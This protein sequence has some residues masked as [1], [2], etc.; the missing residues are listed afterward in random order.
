MEVMIMYSKEQAI[1]TGIVLMRSVKMSPSEQKL[2]SNI[3]HQDKPTQCLEADNINRQ[4]LEVGTLVE[5]TFENVDIL[6][7]CYQEIV[8]KSGEGD[9]MLDDLVHLSNESNMCTDL[10]QTQI[11]KTYSSANYIKETVVSIS[12]LAYKV[13]ILAMNANIE[14]A[15]AGENGR[16]F[17]TIAKEVK[18]LA[19]QTKDFSEKITVAVKELMANAESNI[20]IITDVLKKIDIQNGKL[21]ETKNV[22][23]HLTSKMA[24]MSNAIEEITLDMVELDETKNELIEATSVVKDETK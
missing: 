23:S 14:A 1:D 19:N 5:R 10:I 11:N 2:E 22:F 8:V 16:V 6:A 4:A 3:V 21:L 9:E 12:S 7:A 18:K 15:R 17:F 13:N 24:D 20:E